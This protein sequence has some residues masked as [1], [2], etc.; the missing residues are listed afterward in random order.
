MRT[1][2]D[3]WYW[4]RFGLMFG[5]GGLMSTIQAASAGHPEGLPIVLSVLA[6]ASLVLAFAMTRFTDWAER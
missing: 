6:C 3:R 5:W 4:V 2:R 1:F